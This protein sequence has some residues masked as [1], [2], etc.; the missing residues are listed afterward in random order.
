[1]IILNI[2]NFGFPG[3]INFIGE[4]Y[5]LFSFYSV[6]Y[7][8]MLILCINSFLTLVFSMLFYLKLNSGEFFI[9]N[10]KRRARLDMKF[11]H[12]AILWY[13]IILIIFLGIFPSELTNILEFDI[14]L[15]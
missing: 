2:S 12:L 14:K 15:L 4:F 7:F 9:I 13:M 1:L 8:Y 3:T 10:K 5:A 6:N 11:V